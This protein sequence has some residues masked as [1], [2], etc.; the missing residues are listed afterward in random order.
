MLGERAIRADRL[1]GGCVADVRLIRLASGMSVVAKVGA[2]AAAEA[3][4]L[5]YLAERSE[6][7]VPAVLGVEDDLLLLEH[8]EHDGVRSEAGE[9]EAAEMLAALHEIEASAFGMGMETLIGPLPRRAGWERSW[10]R[11]WA[12]HRLLPMGECALS[13]GG[14]DRGLH[15]RLT[16]LVDRLV[17]L[18]PEAPAASLVHGDVW[19]GNVLW[20]GG[21]VA[22]FI[23]PACHHA[24]AEVELAFIRLF[25]KF[26]G[27]FWERYGELRGLDAAFERERVHVYQLE[28]LLVHAT[29]FGSGYASG[30]DR[31]LS[32]IGF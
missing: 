24:H 19:G 2:T 31:A 27:V 15:G 21:R 13:A 8:I 1:G 26:G 30:I 14:I 10:V 4:M 16:G 25:S 22:G 7:P 20:R 3:A 18:V 29:L 28:P 9:R 17:E 5:G 23:D 12:E 11:F 32:A 6:L